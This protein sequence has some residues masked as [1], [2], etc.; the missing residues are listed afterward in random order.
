MVV[1]FGK[2][3]EGG[4]LLIPIVVTLPVGVP[5][6]KTPEIQHFCIGLDAMF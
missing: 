6:C 5:S 3:S 4:K 1:T 2:E